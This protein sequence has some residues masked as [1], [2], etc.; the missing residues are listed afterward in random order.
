[1]LTIELPWP[2]RS[3]APNRVRG[4]WA[5]VSGKR[6]AAFDEAYVLTFQAVNQHKG[7]WFDLSAPS[8][9]ITI[10]FNP[11]DKRRRDLDGGLSSLK[12]S[13]DGIATALTIDDSKFCPITLQRGEVRKG[14]SVTVAI[15]AHT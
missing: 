7:P 6:A 14:G 2:D 4:H 10:T 12:Q 1:M 15:G 11:P 5:K 3:L 13:L 9:P 8:V